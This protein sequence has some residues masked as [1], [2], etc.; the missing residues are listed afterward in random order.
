MIQAKDFFRAVLIVFAAALMALA[1]NAASP[2][3]IAWVGTWPSTY[4]ADT[5]AV[6]PSYQTGDPP[7]LRLDEAIA[8]FQSSEA[9]FVDAR[10]PEDYA[11]GHIPGAISFPFD[12]YDENADRALPLLSKDKEIVVYCGGADCELSLYLARQLRTV[13]YEHLAIFFG[14][15]TSWQESGLPMEVAGS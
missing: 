11:A 12:E 3:H 14:G 7:I 10:E 1:V 6:P 2:R 8:K 13:G 4:G 5:A 15:I 9:I